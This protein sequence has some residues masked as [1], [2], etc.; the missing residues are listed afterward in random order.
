MLMCP[1][2]PLGGK[3]RYARLTQR[4]RLQLKSS[5]RR[6]SVKEEAHLWCRAQFSSVFQ[7]G[8]QKHFPCQ[9]ALVIITGITEQREAQCVLAAQARAPPQCENLNGDEKNER[10]KGQKEENR[11][12]TGVS[13]LGEFPSFIRFVYF[14]QRRP[15]LPVVG[16]MGKT[17][18]FVSWFPQQQ[19][20][21][22]LNIIWFKRELNQLYTSKCVYRCCEVVQ[23]LW[24]SLLLLQ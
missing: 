12:H 2:K 11:E 14:F 21:Y 8:F 23:H 9:R 20:D 1:S 7:Q 5:Y 6:R 18:W 3:G 4:E 22:L 16:S 13:S 24:D 17:T 19:A 15:Q 10:Q